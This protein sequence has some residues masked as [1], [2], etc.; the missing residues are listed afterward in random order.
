MDKDYDLEGRID[1]DDFQSIDENE[2][3][4]EE[5]YDEEEYYNEGG[6]DEEEYY[7][8]DEYYDDEE[9]EEEYYTSKLEEIFYKILNNKKI[10]IGIIAIIVILVGGKMLSGGKQ[11]VQLMVGITEDGLPLDKDG[12]IIMPSYSE[13]GTLLPI[14]VDPKFQE[15][16][17]ENFYPGSQAM[18]PD[19]GDIDLD[20]WEEEQV[21]NPED[22]DGNDPTNTTGNQGEETPKFE[23][24]DMLLVNVDENFYNKPNNNLKIQETRY[25]DLGIKLEDMV[26]NP[27]FIYNNE[28]TLLSDN[29]DYVNREILGRSLNYKMFTEAFKYK[30]ELV[31]ERPSSSELPATISIDFDRDKATEIIKEELAKLKEENIYKDINMNTDDYIINSVL[32]SITKMVVDEGAASE[33]FIPNV[34]FGVDT[35]MNR[36]MGQLEQDA[37]TKISKTTAPFL[38]EEEIAKL[39]LKVTKYV[40]AQELAELENEACNELNKYK[41]GICMSPKDI[42]TAEINS[43]FI[44]FLYDRS[45]E[46]ASKQMIYLL[47]RISDKVNK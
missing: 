2:Y 31:L 14:K 19:E 15:E 10:I 12:N 18:S 29:K 1:G 11:K 25:R 16:F 8:E 9:Y 46:P 44:Q 27:F 17:G 30:V 21:Q 28:G 24:K 7:D 34:E 38:T 26:E 35:D 13:D 23:E 43:E 22:A 37:I 42:S 32:T 3:Y 45:L 5:G 47:Y 4:D 39:H 41:R 33:L 6:Y 36:F 40:I 20:K